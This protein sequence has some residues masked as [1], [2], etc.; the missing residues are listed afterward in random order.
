[1]LYQRLY[2]VKSSPT[3]D[4][5]KI[6]FA[7]I[8]FDTI[9]P[10]MRQ[11][12]RIVVT[13][14]DDGNL[15][16][17]V[18]GEL[19]ATQVCSA[20]AN[21]FADPIYIGEYH[22]AR[23]NQFFKMDGV[24]GN[25]S[26]LNAELSDEDVLYDY[27]NQE[28]IVGVVRGE[29]N[30]FSFD[31]SNIKACFPSTEGVGTSITNIVSEVSSEITNYTDTCWGNM[32]DLNKGIQN[33]F[34]H[35]DINGKILGATND[36]EI[37]YSTNGYLELPESTVVFY[38]KCL[39]KLSGNLEK[40][41]LKYCDG[42]SSVLQGVGITDDFVMSISVQDG[43]SITLPLVEGYVYDMV[44]DWGDG[45]ESLVTSFD[46][47]NTH[48]YTVSNIYTVRFSGTCEA[49][50]F[51]GS[52]MTTNLKT[53][54]NLG[55]MVW[56]DFN[57]AFKECYS[58][59][60]I[61]TKTTNTSLV[62][63][64]NSMF[65]GLV[66]FVFDVE[67]NTSNVTDMGD[68][69]NASNISNIPVLGFNTSKV[70]N[71]SG[72]FQDTISDVIDLSSFDT[73]NVLNMDYM[74]QRC[75]ADT[76]N[77]SSFDV[78]KI[79]NFSRMFQD[80]QAEIDTSSFITTSL[81]TCDN[82]FM[83]CTSSV[84]NVSGFDTSQSLNMTSM[85][86]D[87]QALALDTSS[88]DT[89]KVTNMTSMFQNSVGSVDVS[90]FDTSSVTLMDNMF[91]IS[92]APIVDVSG[93]NV[94]KVTS[95]A[96]V[97]YGC[98]AGTIDVSLWDTSS[99]TS[100]ASTFRNLYYTTDLKLG[101]IDTSK[102]TRMDG[103]FYNSRMLTLDVSNLN[104]SLVTTTREM[105]RGLYTPVL[106]FSGLDTS[107]VTDMYAMFYQSRCLN[108]D[109][110]TFDTSSLTSMYYMFGAIT[111]GETINISGLLNPLVTNMALMFYN[112][113]SA[114]TL[115]GFQTPSVTNMD[116]MF[117]SVINPAP[118]DLTS[119]DTSNVVNMNEMFGYCT[120]SDI[121]VSSFDTSKVPS[122]NYMFRYTHSL[123]LD[124]ST[125]DITSTTSMISMFIGSGMTTENYDKTLLAWEAQ[126]YKLNV[127]VDFGYSIYTLGG[128]GETARNNL[129]AN[130][131]I[132]T[133]GGYMFSMYDMTIGTTLDGTREVE[134]LTANANAVLHTGQAC[135]FNGVDQCIN[136]EFIPNSTTLSFMCTLRFDAISSD[137]AGA[138]VKD[139]NTD[140]RLYFGL[141]AGGTS[142]GFGFSN[143]YAE[144]STYADVI[145]EH[146]E[147]RCVVTRR[148]DGNAYIYVNGI[149]ELTIAADLI[150]DALIE[151]FYL[152]AYNNYALGLVEMNGTNN[153]M[154][155]LN[156]ELSEDDIIYDFN[157]QEAIID[158]ALGK[159][160]ENFS[161]NNSDIELCYT[162]TE[163]Q[164]SVVN[165]IKR[166]L[167]SD[168]VNYTEACWSDTVTSEKG[169][170]NA[171]LKRD[172]DGKVTGL[173]NVG[174]L[175]PC[176]G[177]IE[178]PLTETINHNIT[179]CI[180]KIDAITGDSATITYCDTTTEI[181][182]T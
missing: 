109:V 34:F 8:R 81:N 23:Y 126:V 106:D 54:E 117:R 145:S 94:S 92:Q 160:N 72:M 36:G 169:L 178:I 104:T 10:I 27:N 182:P 80:T 100:M 164:G 33:A 77:L 64:M 76:I 83:D 30:N 159:T 122:F 55:N 87:T 49:I 148:S 136:T 38:N 130:G 135:K 127:T 151:S 175:E 105:F 12:N 88:F 128:A 35:R 113:S 26:Y 97:F 91:Y 138:G 124:V 13:R 177:Y 44:V 157:N 60:T 40:L 123:T 14:R 181:I 120:A 131:W 152:G 141:Y 112:T 15:Y 150:G 166:N 46:N 163:G 75:T 69:F 39:T 18:N 43:E 16:V 65:M 20:L 17:F 144:I 73:S 103:L 93:F 79:T 85:F 107:K 139:N 48:T 22:D 158:V 62:T 102:V 110:S 61:K 133:D 2:V 32:D 146:D 143:R 170:Q 28:A 53:I 155:I 89:S 31:K 162:L 132:I 9:L 179:K 142:L 116:R 51:G 24:I 67:L 171:L 114:I 119:F 7:N 78:S 154:Q 70:T 129:I 63:N 82:M 66:P 57:G 134:N 58:L 168:I 147:L 99:V 118:L 90:G 47:N 71:M 41:T 111:L 176:D 56:R 68:M 174:E 149:L 95:L 45:N 74:F 37:G 153:S 96:N 156:K 4:K 98:R 165:D 42:T 59:N 11:Y 19:I 86:Q 180:D 29:V 5:L 25:S 173:A 172:I 50:S 3:N 140:G 161:F 21:D 137:W 121:I 84:I 115:T 125:F 1:M 52:V 6:G 101:N 108:I 167:Q